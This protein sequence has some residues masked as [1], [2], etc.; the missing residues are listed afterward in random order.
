MPMPN[1]F[2]DSNDLTGAH[3]LFLGFSGYDPFAFDDF[4]YLIV[5]MDV[6]SGTRAGAETDV[7][8]IKLLA[9][10]GTDNY[11]ELDLAFK[12]I[13]SRR[14]ELRLRLINADD[15][16]SLSSWFSIVVRITE[17][18]VRNVLGLSGGENFSC[19]RLKR[20][21]PV[22]ARVIGSSYFLDMIRPGAALTGSGRQDESNDHDIDAHTEYR[23]RGDLPTE[24]R[25]E[26]SNESF[27]NRYVRLQDQCYMKIT[28]RVFRN[29]DLIHR[30]LGTKRF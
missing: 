4:Q 19:H 9:I 13:G 5:L 21:S 20:N 16:H 27:A 28:T 6:R 15:L 29:G 7:N 11:L 18:A 12:I 2:R 30:L 23:K 17:M 8:E 26:S 10:D 22:D 14:I 24:N 3:D 25:L 1:P